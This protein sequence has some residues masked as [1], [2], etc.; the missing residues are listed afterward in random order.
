MVRL[1]ASSGRRILSPSCGLTHRRGDSL[2]RCEGSGYR[3]GHPGTC[4]SPIGRRR[5]RFRISCSKRKATCT[6]GAAAHNGSAL[7][8]GWRQ[9]SSVLALRPETL[10]GV[11]SIEVSARRTDGGTQVLLFAKDLPTRLADA[12]TSLRNPSVFR[13]DGAHRHRLLCELF[14]D[15]AAGGIRLTISRY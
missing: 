8:H 2:S 10:A 7:R 1:Y 5:I 4:S 13:P 6:P 9:T 11:Q 3:S 15:A 14:L 12:V